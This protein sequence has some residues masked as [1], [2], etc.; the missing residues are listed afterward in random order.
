[1]TQQLLFIDD[2]AQVAFTDTTHT[3]SHT[4]EVQTTYMCD[5]NSNI[6]S[7]IQEDETL[8]SK[9]PTPFFA[10]H[11]ELGSNGNNAN[12]GGVNSLESNFLATMD[13]LMSHI[14]PENPYYEKQLGTILQDFVFEVSGPKARKHA[15]SIT[16]ILIDLSIDDIKAFMQDFEK[17]KKLV[18]KVWKHIRKNRR[19]SRQLHG[20]QYFY[21][22]NQ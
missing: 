3:W 4:F 6:I 22:G 20:V 9:K 19:L 18:A 11:A 16:G 13:I 14:V 17:F 5:S 10:P 1:M 21:S 12:G 7:L 2:D 8:L 15:V